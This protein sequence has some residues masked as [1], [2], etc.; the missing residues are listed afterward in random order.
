V[1]AEI[2]VA[3]EITVP[4]ETADQS[5]LAQVVARFR[6]A[7]P[8]A[9]RVAYFDHAAVAPLPGVTRD[10]IRVWLDHATEEGDA[11]WPRWLR[12]LAAVR[13]TAARLIQADPAEIAFVPNT[14]SGIG[15]VAEGLPWQSG[16][17]AVTLANEFPSNQ[18]PWMNLASRG[19]ELRRVPVEGGVVD[20]DRLE[21]ACDER[22]R[23]VSLSWVG[24][25][26]GWRIEPAEV[27]AVCRRRGCLFFL[28]AIQGL[29][30]F[31]LDVRTAGVDFLAADGHKW[32]LGPEGAGLLFIRK[33][34][35]PLLRPLMVGW[36]SVAQGNDYTRV[37]LNLRPDAARYEGGSY[38]MIGLHG[39]GASLDLLESLGVGPQAS[40]VAEQVLALADHAASELQE[41]G[42]TLLAPRDG[43]HRSG[44]VTFQLPRH[45]P[46]DI[47]RRLEAAGIVV[48]CRAGGVRLSPHGYNTLDEIERMFAE[49]RR[50]LS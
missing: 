46:H 18:Y 30:V 20:L 1:P 47:R 36:N 27:A 5:A 22:T 29:G 49:L 25:A 4:A 42:A 3:A 41:L 13:Q 37:E 12:R 43:P 48:R 21:A 40:P 10:S 28:D 23:L 11:A 45:D 38:N 6:A 2:T 15:L 19:V 7:M 9:L 24:Y 16:D 33:E 50:M 34:C 31:P 8:I 39:L 32:L 44:I 26:T 17:N 35:L 14:T